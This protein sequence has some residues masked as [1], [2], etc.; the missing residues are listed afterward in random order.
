MRG[1]YSLFGLVLTVAASSVALAH[2]PK[3]I[4]DDPI[5]LNQ[6]KEAYAA[7]QQ[8][9]YATALAKWRPLAEQGS[10]AAQ[11]F[12]GFMHANGQGVAKDDARAVYWYS[13]AAERDNMVAQ[14]RLAIMYRDGTGTDADRVRALMWARMAG[15]SEH[16][17]QKVAQA[18]QRSLE[19]TMTADEIAAAEEM[20]H[21]QSNKH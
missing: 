19:K 7:Y 15:R 9:D 16:H 3:D 8:S 2:G 17:M 13:E 1:K 11:L 14:V 10:S 5:L 18:L 6:Y 20:F 12:V 4:P 21:A